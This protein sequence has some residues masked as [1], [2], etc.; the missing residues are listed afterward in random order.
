[1]FQD[2][3]YL[4]LWETQIL[5]GPNRNHPLT[6][7]LLSIWLK[8]DTSLRKAAQE[9]ILEDQHTHSVIIQH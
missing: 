1:M 3:R 8:Q 2:K 6:L 5:P 4:Q 7:Y 9:F